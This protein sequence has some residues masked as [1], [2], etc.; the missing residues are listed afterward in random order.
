MDEVRFNEIY[1]KCR[2]FLVVCAIVNTVFTLVGESIRGL[3][4]L[5]TKLKE[6][7][8]I[9]LEDYLSMTFEDMMKNIGEQVIKLT[10]DALVKHDKNQLNEASSNCIKSLIVDLSSKNLHENSVYKLLCKYFKL[11]KN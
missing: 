1:V 3:E 6:N 5:R 8:L 9:L 4:E 2:K 7:I 11:F 10:N